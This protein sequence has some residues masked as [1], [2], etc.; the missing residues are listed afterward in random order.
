MCTAS[1]G[2]AS[3]QLSVE[4]WRDD[5]DDPNKLQRDRC[6]EKANVRPAWQRLQLGR[7]LGK[8][9]NTWKEHYPCAPP[10]KRALLL[11]AGASIAYSTPHDNRGLGSTSSLKQVPNA[12]AGTKTC[13]KAIQSPHRGHQARTARCFQ[14][15]TSPSPP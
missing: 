14:V 6:N 8:V 1:I 12:T 9:K 4:R 13:K 2:P 3:T 10:S 5:H 7:S 11:R 15:Y